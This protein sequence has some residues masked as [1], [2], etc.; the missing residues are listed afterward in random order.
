MT[1]YISSKATSQKEAAQHFLGAEGKE[2]THSAISNEN[3]IQWKGE[4]KILDEGKLKEFVTSK[5][6]LNEWLNDSL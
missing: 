4:T 3:N 5:L 6:V 1:A 2:A